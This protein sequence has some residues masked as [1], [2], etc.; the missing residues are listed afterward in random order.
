MPRSDLVRSHGLGELAERS[1][2]PQ[3]SF[4]FGGQFVVSASDVRHEGVPC[5]DDWGG[6]EAFESA[7]RTDPGLESSMVAFNWVVRVAGI[8]V[9]DLGQEFVQD[10]RVG[11]GPVGDHLRR[12][13]LA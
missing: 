3:M 10:P 7:H 6:S 4:G 9:V 1:R 8:R 2:E 12:A 13:T 11:R 5:T